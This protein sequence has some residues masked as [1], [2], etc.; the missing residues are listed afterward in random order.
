MT[1]IE[2]PL[3][4]KERPV[5]PEGVSAPSISYDVEPYQSQPG[6]S[7]QKV[8]A[9]RKLVRPLIDLNAYVCRAEIDWLEF[10]INTPDIHQ[11]RNMQ[12]KIAGML[13]ELGSKSTVFVTG[14]G[15]KIRYIGRDFIVKF[16]QPEPRELAQVLAKIAGHYGLDCAKIPELRI[17]GIEVSVD[18]YVKGAKGLTE[19]AANLKRWQLVDILRRHLKPDPVLTELPAAEPRF[20]GGKFGGGGATH[21]VNPSAS[22]LGPRLLVLASRLGLEPENLVALDMNKHG[23]PDVDTTSW[24]GPKDFHVMLRTMDKVTDKRDPASDTFMDLSME[25]RRARV[26]VTLRGK[27]DEIGGHGAVGLETLGDLAGFPFKSIRRPFFEFYLATIGD[28]CDGTSLGIKLRANEQEIFRRS[29]VY[30]LDR[31]HRAVQLVNQARITRGEQDVSLVRLGEKGRM[32]SWM[33]M[34]QKIDR[35]LKKLGKDW[36]ALF[37]AVE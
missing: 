36:G 37:E 22:D 32:L 8:L 19:S 5:W 4:F 13:N 1:K 26:E 16:Q 34:N 28:Q 27:A 17:M 10:C 11:A 9:G 21:F 23:K 6:R 7:V 3:A 14:P 31:F 30:G 25:E 20:F 2:I 33:D 12:P 18:F 15:R 29:G 24:I 35:A